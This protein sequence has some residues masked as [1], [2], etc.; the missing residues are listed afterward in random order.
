MDKKHK[1]Q[2]REEYEE[3]LRAYPKDRCPFC[4]WPH[5]QIV[6]HEGRNWV[7]IYNRF[8]YWKNQTMLLPKRHIKEITELSVSEMGELIEMYD[9]AITKFRDEGIGDKY[10]MFWRLRD[11]QIDSISGNKR[12]AH[13]HINLVTD[14]DHLWDPLIDPEAV[15]CDFAKLQDKHESK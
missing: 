2:T 7:W 5:E 15:K 12:P 10:V 3:Y 11:R 9:H 13:L 4:D 8:P 14:R 1:L 6:L